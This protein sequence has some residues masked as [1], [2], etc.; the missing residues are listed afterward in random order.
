M[1]RI[2][3]MML[4]YAEAVARSSANGDRA[5][6]LD[7]VRQI[8]R[9]AFGSSIAAANGLADITDTQLTPEFVLDERARELH[10]EG[11]RRSDLIRFN[12]FVENTYLWPWKGGVAAG[13]SVDVKYKLFP[14][15][16][17]DLTANPN[18]TQNTGY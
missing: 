8:R 12:K 2:S 4:I 15:P 14:I 3:D 13:R 18:L 7:Y 6:A 9:R 16:L 5:I 17:S 11:L 10:W 1:L